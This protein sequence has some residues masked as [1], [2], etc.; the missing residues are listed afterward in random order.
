MLQTKP[1]NAAD[2][3]PILRTAMPELD[4]LRG[5]AILMVLFYHAYY[6]QTNLRLFPPLQRVF[7][8][9]TGS[10]RFGVNLF[11]VLSGFLITGILAD[12]RSRLDYYK[13]FY[14][15]RALRIAP[16]YL[17]TI[18]ILFIAGATSTKFLGLS[19]LYLSN[20]AS[21]FGVPIGY[22]VLWSLSVEE[23]F[24]LFWPIVSRN[25]SNRALLL[26]AAA[27]I[28]VSPFL[29]L[30]T[31]FLYLP[32]GWVSYR[33]FEYTW[34][35]LDGLVC[36][37]V[38]ALILRE[39]SPDRRKFALA[40]GTVGALAVLL[41]LA[42]IPL[43]ILDRHRPV[44]AALQVVPLHFA[45]T[46]F[47]GSVLLLGSGPWRS[48]LRS[49]I[50]EFFGRISYGLYLYHLMFFGYSSGWSSGASSTSSK[51]ISFWAS[52]SVLLSWAPPPSCSP[53]FLA[54][55]SKTPSSSSKPSGLE[56]LWQSL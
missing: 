20:F 43:G 21:F 47:L 13:R 6:W 18:L 14:I 35:S 30:A 49:G 53:I 38:I 44:G 19:L 5:L 41:L 3:L 27:I 22:D 8:T 51:S 29:R 54:V 11:F 36:G 4:S 25:L 2:N 17:F 37:A 1:P 24:Y 16:A 55:S 7:L 34:N 33:V 48:H 50:L 45:F 26:F 28:F 39:F 46:A 56:T 32:K 42:G 40:L 15:R 23:H 10:G 12:S 52:P 31:F 9:I